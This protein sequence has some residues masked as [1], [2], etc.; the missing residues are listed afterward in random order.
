M[1]E[2]GI[3]PIYDEIVSWDPARMVILVITNSAGGGEMAQWGKHLLF[4]HQDLSLGPQHPH[5]ARCGHKAYSHRD[6]WVETGGSWG[7]TGRPALPK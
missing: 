2:T 4:K 6:G 3:D 7:H 5:R 1:N